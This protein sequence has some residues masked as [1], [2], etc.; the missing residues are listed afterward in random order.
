MPNTMTL[1]SSSTVGSGGAA[2]ISFSSIPS[3]YTDLL[4]KV[5]I[6]TNRS[7][8]VDDVL[9]IQPNGSSS[10]LTTIN[11]RGNGSGAASG[12]NTTWSGGYIVANGATSNTFGNLEVYIPNYAGANNKSWS[13]DAV[14]ENNATEA[15]A[16][17]KAVLWSQTTAISSLTLVPLYGTSFSQYSTAY[18]YGIVKS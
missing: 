17:L 5:S 3:T 11:L 2:S 14:A 18:L 6:R 7:G 9:Q 16:E 13:V 10:N 15:Y 1:I 4:L 12:S 8:A